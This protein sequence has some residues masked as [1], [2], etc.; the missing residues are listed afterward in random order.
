MWAVMCVCRHVCHMQAESCL[1]TEWA[2]NHCFAWVFG[3][4]HACLGYAFLATCL[5]ADTIHFK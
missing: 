2:L 1:S 3:R 4:S 5:L